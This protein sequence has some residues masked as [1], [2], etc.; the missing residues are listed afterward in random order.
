MKNIHIYLLALVASTAI[1]SE[2][3]A[4]QLPVRSTYLMTPFQDHVAS[5]GN[6]PCLDMRMGFRNQWVGFEGAP[7]YS[8]ASL[9]GRLSETNS[10]IHGIGGRIETDAAGP[11][12]TTSFSMAYA[13][14]LKMTNG[15]WLSTGL[16]LGLVQHR[17][18]IG[19]LDFPDFEAAFDPAV[20][21]S[22]QF[23][24]PTIDAGVWY[25]DKH[26]FIGISMINASASELSEMTLSTRTSRHVIATAGTSVDLDGRFM[27]KPSAQIRMVSG[28]PASLDVTALLSYDNQFSIGVGYR[29]QTALIAHLQLALMDYITVGYAYDFGI[30]EIRIAAANSHEVTIA[31]SACD[32]RS[33]RAQHCSAYD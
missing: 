4:Q 11:W 3:T 31:L 28:L 16:S 5:A 27:F 15:G 17:L 29:N 25:E 7:S 9:S 2:L 10:S 13:Y 14:K 24:F 1:F 8:F 20:T 26:S 33:K 6:K 21:A 23:L 30:S 32:K 12:G 18:N 22:T 19:S